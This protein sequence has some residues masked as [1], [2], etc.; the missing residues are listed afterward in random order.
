MMKPEQ[1]KILVVDDEPEILEIIRSLFEQ[2]NF[3]VQIANS[4]NLAWKVLQKLQID[5]VLSDIRM[6]DGDGID[7]AKNIRNN[8]PSKPSILFMTGFSDLLNEEIFHLGAE[9]KFTKPFDYNAVRLAIETC[10]LLPYLRWKTP[11]QN[12]PRRVK[13]HAVSESIESLEK[14]KKVFFG[15]GGFFIVY[16]KSPPEK[17]TV[18]SF[19]IEVKKPT[20]LKFT[21]NGIVR[22]SHARSKSGIPAGLGIEISYMNKQDSNNYYKAFNSVPYFIPSPYKLLVD[23]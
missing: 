12:D 14:S 16:D 6:P 19:E 20:L 3:S 4:G 10:M 22:W 9:G 13:L 21:G 7:L 23:V 18:V 1:V 8:H 15:R 11:P 17:G 2:F 5:L